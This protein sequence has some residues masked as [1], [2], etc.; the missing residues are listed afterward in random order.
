MKT[1][2]L[3]NRNWKSYSEL[4]ERCK[5]ITSVKEKDNYC[6]QIVREAS[7]I[8][9]DY[10]EN[11]KSRNYAKIIDYNRKELIKF[12]EAFILL[13]DDP[14]YENFKDKKENLCNF[15]KGKIKEFTKELENLSPY[16]SLDI[17]NKYAKEIEV[18]YENV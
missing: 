11:F 16:V 10:T 8:L 2:S 17:K 13:K 1:I 4:I 5:R 3:V 7:R 6:N 12:F 14:N 15:Y 9:K 18:I